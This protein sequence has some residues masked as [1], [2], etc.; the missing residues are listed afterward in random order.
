[1]H[2]YILRIG[3]AQVIALV[4][5]LSAV[6]HSD[7]RRKDSQC[8]CVVRVV[9]YYL[10]SVPAPRRAMWYLTHATNKVTETLGHWNATIC[11]YIHMDIV[12]PIYVHLWHHITIGC[13]QCIKKPIF[14]WN[15]NY[16]NFCECLKQVFVLVLKL[17]CVYSYAEYL[18][19]ATLVFNRLV[20]Y[21]HMNPLGNRVFS[22]RLTQCDHQAG[23]WWNS[24]YDRIC[25]LR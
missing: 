25:R 20:K 7:D 3:T 16:I 13:N 15:E 21:L 14:S 2:A 9:R 19:T 10:Q 4:S 8:Y 23:P 24:D 5:A 17:T 18:A 22:Q 6:Y 11:T 1:M 12:S